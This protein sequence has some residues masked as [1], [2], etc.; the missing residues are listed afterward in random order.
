VT[1]YVWVLARK[2]EEFPV[3]AACAMAKV[4]TT[5]FNDWR[6]Q[7]EA[8]PTAAE[9]E[10]AALVA[11]MWEIHAESD[12]SYGSPRMTVELNNQGWVV[13][14][15]RVERLMALHGIVG[16]HKP[17]RVR[18]TI[19]AEDSPPLPDLVNRAFKPGK[20]D[21]AWVGDIT[22]IPTGEGWLYLATVIDLGS[23]RLVG[24]SMAEHMRT[25]LVTD[26]LD[27][28]AAV[29]GGRTRRIIFHSDRG[30]QY[31]SGDY[32]KAMWKHQ[33]RQSVGR[34]G[35]CWDNA[36]AES[37]FSSLKRELVSQYRF[38]TR[39]EARRAIFAW[40]IR[41]NTTRLHSSLGY[42]SPIAWENTHTRQA[43]QAA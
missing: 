15:K 23:R 32:A 7:R 14:H 3:T 18:T 42:R 1:R 8:D 2:A 43:N 38:A 31:M 39:A 29:R 11:A 4:S 12:K 30:A 10:Q 20:T 21:V 5:A 17:A 26:A 27:M 40:T 34:T 41:Y 25:E 22:Y 37:F 33:M 19:P 16:I 28:A 36:V 9:L 13:N 24:Y 6:R 35:V